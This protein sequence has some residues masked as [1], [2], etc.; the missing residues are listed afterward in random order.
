MHIARN[1]CCVSMVSLTAPPRDAMTDPENFPLLPRPAGDGPA[2][3]RRFADLP[4]PS[5]D[6]ESRFHAHY[7]RHR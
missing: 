4:T 1:L 7:S 5:P 3:R 2:G 6:Q